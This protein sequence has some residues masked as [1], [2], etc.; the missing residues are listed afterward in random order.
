MKL[1]NIKSCLMGTL[2][3]TWTPNGAGTTGATTDWM[4]GCQEGCVEL[5]P[6]LA[7]LHSGKWPNSPF[8]L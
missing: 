4:Q 1:K 7:V 6:A 5:H 2:L 8:R 3:L